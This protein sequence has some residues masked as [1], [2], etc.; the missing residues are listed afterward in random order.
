MFSKTPKKFTETYA[1]ELMKGYETKHRSV[2]TSNHWM[3]NVDK[4]VFESYERYV[5][6]QFKHSDEAEIE[7][8]RK[9]AIENL[10]PGTVHYFH[11]YF[12]DLVK[13]K[14]KV[15][16]FTSQEKSLYATFNKKFGTTP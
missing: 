11:L 10:I 8:E 2:P 13:R 9:A 4:T 3:K 6:A 7:N 15:D 16:D 14:K 1:K 12:L 5:M